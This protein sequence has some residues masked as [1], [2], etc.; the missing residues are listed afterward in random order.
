MQRL[1]AARDT[2]LRDLASA[3]QE[4]AALREAA[5]A[6]ERTAFT[7]LMHLRE[8]AAKL[9][10]SLAASEEEKTEVAEQR[11][12]ALQQ[13]SACTYLSLLTSS[14]CA[15]HA[16][17]SHALTC[18]PPRSLHLILPSPA[19]AQQL[20]DRVSAATFAAAAD[21][22]AVEELRASERARATTEAEGLRQRAVAAENEKE[23]ATSSKRKAVS[24]YLVIV[25]LFCR[26]LE[27]YKKK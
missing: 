15:L 18:A 19:Q 27:K 12:K 22:A 9:R 14:S 6:A 26:Y 4:S 10:V 2:S 8:E 20:R 1:T 25:M 16:L 7:Q 3:Q 13:V 24:V 5:A 23:A 17:P 11:D 21:V